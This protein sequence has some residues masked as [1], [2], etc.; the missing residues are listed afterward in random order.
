M[1]ALLSL[2]SHVT[3]LVAHSNYTM[4]NRV[5]SWDDPDEAFDSSEE[6]L[7]DSPDPEWIDKELIPLL[8]TAYGQRDPGY[9]AERVEEATDN[10]E[11]LVCALP[12]N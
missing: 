6:L 3:A 10:I 12:T 5:Y 1:I 8:E 9:W 2:L 11:D 7:V 4:A